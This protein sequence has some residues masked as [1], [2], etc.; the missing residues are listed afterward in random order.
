MSSVQPLLRQPIIH[1]SDNNTLAHYCEHWLRCRLLAIDTEF[2]RVD[3]YYPIAAVIQVNDG[4]ANYLIDPLCITQWSPL[5]QVMACDDVIKAFHACS[6]DLDVFNNLLG[7]LPVKLFDTQIAA[8][9]LGIGASVGYGN[10]VNECLGV[11]LP[12]GET[13]SN[14]L[15]RPLSD[16]Q[17]HYA[18]LDV[19]YLFELASLLEKKLQDLERESWLYEECEAAIFNYQSNLDPASSFY[20]SNNTWRLDAKSLV[21]AKQLFEWRENTAREK[22][23]PKTRIIKDAQIFE[24]LSRMPSTLAEF[25]VIGLHDSA[26]RKFGKNMLEI[27]NGEVS[28][29]KHLAVTAPDLPLTKSEREK[30]KKM[31]GYVTELAQQHAIAPEVL[32]KKAVYQ[33]I[34]RN[35][36]ADLT[37]LEALQ[38]STKGWRQAFLKSLCPPVDPANIDSI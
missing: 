31:R 25:K 1:I 18:A 37:Y 19:D 32:I 35:L 11:L 30:V 28:E 26:I 20:K 3:T 14:W 23:I 17:V 24:V 4:Q 5:T 16:G 9:L 29:E 6:E 38:Q 2:M 7:V 34:A 21:L 36:T 33:D 15:V 12:K 8:A 13:R 22:N 10:L 27:V